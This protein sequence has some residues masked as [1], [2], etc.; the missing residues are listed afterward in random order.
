MSKIVNNITAVCKAGRGKA[1]FVA[2]FAAPEGVLLDCSPTGEVTRRVIPGGTLALCN[3]MID[4][5]CTPVVIGHGIRWIKG[6]GSPLFLPRTGASDVDGPTVYLY[7][8]GGDNMTAT[9]AGLNAAGV[10][11]RGHKNETK[12]GLYVSLPADLTEGEAGALLAFA[13]SHATKGRGDGWTDDRAAGSGVRL[14]AVTL[15][16]PVKV[17]GKADGEGAKV[18]KRHNNPGR[19]KGSKNK[20]KDTAD[21]P[22]A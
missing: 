7:G 8:R 1:Q 5:G 16:P 4:G 21:K 12:G 20:D 11:V 10:R 2:P 17:E 18:D 3:A 13:A 6:E 22:A 14:D 9:L 15:A 19:P